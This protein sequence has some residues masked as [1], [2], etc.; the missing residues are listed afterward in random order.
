MA[1]NDE[2]FHKEL[3]V[4]HLEE[5]AFQY[6]TRI[7][8]FS[9]DEVGWQDSE[10]LE[11][12]IEA[13]LD[14]LVVGGDQALRVCLDLL[15]NA[16]FDQLFMIVLLLCRLRSTQ[17]LAQ[18][19]QSF[20]FADDQKLRAVRDAFL[21]ECPPE[22]AAHIGKVFESSNAGL[23]PVLAPCLPRLRL[24]IG[25]AYPRAM[26]KVAANHLP[27]MLAAL[28]LLPDARQLSP[29]L[30][31]LID[32]HEISIA[33]AAILAS[34]L[35]G[36]R[37]ALARCR[38]ESQ[39]FP[40]HLVVAG[41]L[42]EARRILTLAE[43][44]NANADCLLALGLWGNPGSA[45]VLLRYLPHENYG[46]MAAYALHLIT[47]APLFETARD[48]EQVTEDELFEH[49]LDDFQQGNLPPVFAGDDIE[50]LSRDPVRWQEWLV[51]NSAHFQAGQRYRL[52]ELATP[53]VMVQQLI[54]NRTPNRIRQWVY[55][56]LVLRY[57]LDVTFDPRDTVARQQESLR[58]IYQWLVNSAASH[59]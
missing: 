55:L 31:T 59:I 19:W 5:G 33:E 24:S 22:W 56:E 41:E 23:Y 12:A 50:K 51:S 48:S 49:E 42:D 40:L 17:N 29:N 3:Y 9:D 53:A 38:A 10:R 28:P 8:W 26:T 11:L 36:Q 45:P 54:D 6:A 25:A 14:A 16:D 32:H 47:G 39:S 34:L 30:Q 20:D 7:A 46:A 15:P 58:S 44:G 4:E 37:S 52:G 57:G 21:W 1:L 43:A 35:L 18:L 13:H 27:I 2:A